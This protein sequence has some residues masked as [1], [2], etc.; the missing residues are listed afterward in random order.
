M[1]TVSEHLHPADHR[2]VH[3]EQDEVE[4]PAGDGVEG[5]GAVVQRDGVIAAGLLQEHREPVEDR[6][7]VVEDEQPVHTPPIRATGRT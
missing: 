1:T 6:P 4:V 3:V 2:H 7:V 5:P